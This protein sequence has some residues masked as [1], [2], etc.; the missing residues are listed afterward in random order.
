MERQNRLAE[1]NSARGPVNGG[2]RWRRLIREG[3]LSLRFFAMVEQTQ[4][5]DVTR[6]RG[7][8]MTSLTWRDVVVKL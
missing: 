3:G 5:R 6:A 7:V 8:S 1:Q 2:A 4:K